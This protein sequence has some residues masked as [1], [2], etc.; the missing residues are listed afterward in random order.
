[1]ATGTTVY[2]EMLGG[3][4]G[5]PNPTLNK[6]MA[7]QFEKGGSTAAWLPGTTGHAWQAV[8]AN[9]S[10]YSHPAMNVAARVIALTAAEMMI[11]PDVL[12]QAKQDLIAA[13]GKDFVYEA[14]F[15]D[16]QPALDFAMPKKER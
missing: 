1:M 13:R 12:A 2:S 11:S 7:T 8:A 3:V 16:R 5:L 9:G 14:M 6:L 15:G 10:D 4:Y